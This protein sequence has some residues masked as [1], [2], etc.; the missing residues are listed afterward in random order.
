MD[1]LR[2]VAACGRQTVMMPCTQLSVGGLM[3]MQVA[4]VLEIKDSTA[5]YCAE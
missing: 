1:K 4:T 2:F 3:D 5:Q